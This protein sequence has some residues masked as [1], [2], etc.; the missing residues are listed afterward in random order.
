MA[1]ATS[2]W[3]KVHSQILYGGSIPAGWAL[4]GSGCETTDP[5]AAKTLLPAAGAR[6]YGLAFLCSVLAG[7]LVGG[8]MPLHKNRGVEQEGSEHFFYCLDISKFVPPDQFYAELESTMADIRALAPAAGFDRVRLPGELEWERA[9]EW[10]TTG[11]PLHRSHLR[12]LAELA[13][14]MKLATPW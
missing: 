11:I 3:G 12:D 10:R 8:K 2:S 5:S 6:G 9:A 13:E 14:A 7:P 4:D 1:C